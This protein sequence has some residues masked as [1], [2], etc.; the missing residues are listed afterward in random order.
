MSSLQ[1]G[2][3]ENNR[4]LILEMRNCKG[5]LAAAEQRNRFVLEHADT[6]WAPH[7]TPGGMLA[8]LLK[9]HKDHQ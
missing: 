3:L 6:L 1:L 9:E 2:A 7:V 8:Q 4:M 5:D